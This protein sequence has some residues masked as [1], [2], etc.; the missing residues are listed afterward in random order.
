MK[1]GI[2]MFTR[3][4]LTDIIIRRVVK[5]APC[6]KWPFRPEG[7]VRM[8][9]YEVMYI[10]NESV[11][12]EKRAELIENFAKIITDNGGVVNKTDEWGMREFAYRIDYMKKGY[13][14]VVSFEADNECVKE[15]DRLMR[16]NANVVRFLITRDEAPVREAKK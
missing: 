8:K 6:Q 1:S 2:F 12:A 9:K 7:G 14:V 10:I 16:I 3:V 4:S 11:E 5:T 13:Y 15:F